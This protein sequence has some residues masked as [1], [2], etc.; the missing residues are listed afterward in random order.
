MLLTI[1]KV[2][3]NSNQCYLYYLKDLNHNCIGDDI[4]LYY[5]RGQKFFVVPADMKSEML[6]LAHSQFLSSHQGRYETYRC[7]MQ[8]CWW[9]SMFK[10]ISLYMDQCKICLM[11]KTDNHQESNLVKRTFPTKPNEVV[12]I[13][14]IVDLEKSVKCNIHIFTMV[15]KCYKFIKNYA[16]KDRTAIIASRFVYDYCL[17][18]RIP[19]K[20]YADQDPAFE[21]TL[22]T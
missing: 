3:Q 5:H 9:P 18:Y 16:L 6:D 15:D 13:D 4:L 17:V 10:D 12:S 21:A 7:L 14:F 8:S 22:F 20:I 2:L 11:A 19:Q 1:L